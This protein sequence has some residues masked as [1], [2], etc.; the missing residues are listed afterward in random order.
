[1]SEWVNC[2]F[3]WANSSFAHFWAKNERFALDCGDGSFLKFFPTVDEMWWKMV[4]TYCW[5]LSWQPSCFSSEFN[6][7]TTYLCLGKSKKHHIF[8][9]FSIWAWVHTARSHFVYTTLFTTGVASIPYSISPLE[10]KPCSHVLHG[11]PP[12]VLAQFTPL[13]RSILLFLH[14][15]HHHPGL[16]NTVAQPRIQENNRQCYEPMVPKYL[17]SPVTKLTSATSLNQR[18]SSSLFTAI[19]LDSFYTYNS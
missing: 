8:T 5:I 18:W 3:F 15:L 9:Y 14:A 12:P 1:M 19:W 6:P 7:L 2:S 13:C 11:S 10:T 17:P 16:Y 4:W